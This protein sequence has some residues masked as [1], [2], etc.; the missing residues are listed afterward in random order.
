MNDSTS[1]AGARAPRW[2]AYPPDR[3]AGGKRGRVHALV[4]TR[5]SAASRHRSIFA[6]R[7]FCSPHSAAAVFTQ[8]RFFSQPGFSQ[9]GRWLHLC[10]DQKRARVS[11]L[12]ASGRGSVG[13]SAFPSHVGHP[14]APETATSPAAPQHAQTLVEGAAEPRG[15]SCREHCCRPALVRRAVASPQHGSQLG[16]PLQRPRGAG[17]GRRTLAPLLCSSLALCELS[18]QTPQRRWRAAIEEARHGR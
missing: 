10:E 4:L 7:V 12:R 18:P 15:P 8:A 2:P 16:R 9:P 17:H 6:A 1:I 13:D 3:P 11:H 14:C 5:P